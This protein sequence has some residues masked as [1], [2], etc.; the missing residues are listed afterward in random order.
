MSMI[1]FPNTGTHPW[2][3]VVMHLNTRITE[4][5]METSWWA[6]NITCPAY[7]NLHWLYFIPFSNH[8]CIV[9]ESIKFHFLSPN[10]RNDSWVSEPTVQE[11]KESQTG[12]AGVEQ[13]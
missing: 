13:F 7:F 8:D 1:S 6:E 3:V 12:Q 10:P 11:G 5:T 2:T 4:L 9:F